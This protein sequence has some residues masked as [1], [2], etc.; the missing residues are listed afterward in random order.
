MNPRACQSVS[1]LKSD[2]TVGKGDQREA[3]M[4]VIAADAA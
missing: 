4:M 3:A 2:L 1:F